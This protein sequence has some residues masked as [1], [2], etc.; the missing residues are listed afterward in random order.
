MIAACLLA[1]ML[2]STSW[3]ANI[4]QRSLELYGPIQTDSIRQAQAIVVLGAG[5]YRDA[6]E[7]GGL[8]SISRNALFRVRYAAYLHRQSGL[9]ILAAGGAPLG[10]FSEAETMRKVLE[11]E[12]HVKVRW[13]EPNSSNTAENAKNSSAI[14]SKSGITTIALVTDAIHMPRAKLVFEKNGIT[15]MPAPIGFTT[16]S[17]GFDPYL[18]LPSASALAQSSAA[19][20]EWLGLSLARIQ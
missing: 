14:L 7:F 17:P 11:E 6:P 13:L 12:F 15:V 3:L 18:F 8:D 16:D 9:P 20:R 2:L 4:L 10:G 5:T 19:I 1:L